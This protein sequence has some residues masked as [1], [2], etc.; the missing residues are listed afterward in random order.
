MIHTLKLTLGHECPTLGLAHH[1][2][3]IVETQVINNN[4][5]LLSE[6][7]AILILACSGFIKWK[8]WQSST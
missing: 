5:V 6:V 3:S 4:P 1:L 7:T 8:S 2:E